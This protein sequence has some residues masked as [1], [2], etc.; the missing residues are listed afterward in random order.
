M[1]V[2]S[3]RDCRWWML[4]VAGGMVG[5]HLDGKGNCGSWWLKPS[6]PRGV[7]VW[8]RLSGKSWSRFFV[9]EVGVEGMRVLTRAVPEL[10]RIPGLKL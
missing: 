10:F 5:E 3:V 6:R 8:L 2:V 9:E 1:L 4:S 7:V